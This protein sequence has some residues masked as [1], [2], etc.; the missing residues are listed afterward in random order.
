VF[1]TQGKELASLAHEIDDYLCAKEAEQKRKGHAGGH[2]TEKSLGQAR[3]A[4]EQ[5]AAAVHSCELEAC[6][7]LREVYFKMFLEE[8]ARSR[9]AR[10]LSEEWMECEEAAFFFLELSKIPTQF[11]TPEKIQELAAREHEP[12][13]GAPIRH[14]GQ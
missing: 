13:N 1:D 9:T 14:H 10:V 8:R 2:G 3:S 7:D 11:L 12:P 5:W 6:S 4:L